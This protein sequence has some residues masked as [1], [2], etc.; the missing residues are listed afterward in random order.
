MKNI[1]FTITSICLWQISFSQTI[2]PLDSVTNYV[3]KTITVCTK[4]QGTFIA[5]GEKKTTYLS[6]GNPFPNATL[7]AVIFE[8]NLSKFKYAPAEFL[9]DKNICITG[10]VTIY[11]D[12][13]QMIVESE[14]Q[15][16]TDN[17]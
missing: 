3:G 16:K 7:T 4:V 11:K 5:K 2:V 10:K 17:K 13:P 12:K 9:K 15:I 8:D 1:L 14:E 6:F